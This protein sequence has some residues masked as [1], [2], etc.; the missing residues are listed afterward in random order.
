[1]PRRVNSVDSSR[2]KW[3]ISHMKRLTFVR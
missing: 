2:K 1:M 3:K